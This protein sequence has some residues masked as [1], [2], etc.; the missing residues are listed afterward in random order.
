MNF[1][2]IEEMNLTDSQEL[3]IHETISNPQNLFE[4]FTTL[5]SLLQV[6]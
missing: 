3:V 4:Q 2:S 6:Y 5:V 1:V